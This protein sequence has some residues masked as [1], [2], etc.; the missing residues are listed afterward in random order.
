MLVI[1]MMCVFGF[2]FVVVQLID[3]V[4]CCIGICFDSIVDGLVEIELFI[5]LDF[6]VVEGYM[7]EIGDC[8]IIIGVDE[9]GFFYGVQMLLQLFWEDD[10]GWGL[11]CVD[12]VDF[13]WFFCCGVMFD[14]IRYFF[15]VDDVKMF[16]DS[17]SVLKLNYLYLYLSDD[18]GWC[19]Q[20]DF[21]LLLIEWVVV[22]VVDG[23]LG[24]FYIKDDYWEI[25]VYVVVCYM[26]VILEIDLFGY[27]Y[28]I[29]VVYFE[30][31]EVLVM[32][33]V[34]IVDLKCLGQFF[35]V[36]GELYFG[37]GVGYFS[38]C[39]YLECMYEFV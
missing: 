8:V 21:W 38:V 39:I 5:D 4:E 14:V 24:G 28:V 19:V 32:N 10:V 15:G 30:F 22:S 9:V 35:L 2:F 36:V 7:L 13:F 34:L 1:V 12:I 31:V 11:F 17:M 29:G 25:V 20:I 3:V 27:M 16:I 37:W 26:I 23:V 6:F 18:Q 33:D